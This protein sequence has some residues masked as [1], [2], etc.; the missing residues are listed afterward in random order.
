MNFL[1]V[2]GHA[3]I[4]II[5]KLKRFPKPESSIETIGLKRYFGGTGANI[6]RIASSLSVKTALATYVGEDFPNDF[7]IELKR[8]GIDLKDLKKVNGYPTPTCWLFSWAQN[9]IGIMNQ[10]PMRDMEKFKL[11]EHTAKTSDIVHISTGR[12]GYYLKI[13]E[14]A[15]KLGKRIALDPAQELH[16][17]YTP[18]IFERLL[19]K[20]DYFFAGENEC[21][22]ALQYLNLKSPEELTDYVPTFIQ[23]KG[24]KGSVL[25]T[26]KGKTKIPVVKPKRVADAVGAGDAYRAGFYAGLAKNYSLERCCLLGSATASFIVEEK[27]TQTNIPTWKMVM[28]RISRI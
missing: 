2:Y 5:I 25:Y 20:A 4:D 6:A 15:K 3:N 27:G 17:V 23:T 12:P 18:K 1:G 8:E 14:V 26:K 22:T 11:L 19:K 13:I 21:R 24:K 16:Y 28:N 10:G 7:Y 9:H